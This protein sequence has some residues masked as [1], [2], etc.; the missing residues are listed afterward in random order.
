METALTT[1]TQL[2]VLSDTH[3]SPAATPDGTW[4]NTLRRSV[5]SQLLQ[6]ALAEIAQAGHRHVLLLG[7]ISD[8]GTPELIGAALSAIADAGLRSWA[9]PGN[10]DAAEDS[11]ALDTAAEQASSCLVVHHEPLRLGDSM[12]VAGPALRSSDGGQTCEATNLPDVAGVTS[13]ILVWAGHY[14]LLSQ[15]QTLL[16]AGLRYAGDLINRQQARDAAERHAGPVLVLHGHLH[17][18]VT[19]HD[20]RMLQLGFPALVEW[21]HAWTDLRIE[22]SPGGATV[23]TAIRP[24]A[25]E[26]SQRNRNTMLAGPQQ[27]WQL[28]G[29]RWRPVSAP[30]GGPG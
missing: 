5:S 9:V 27:T 15:E 1:A 4:N 3:L 29:E 16:A 26:W 13:P 23:R 25:G 24:V 20:G 6:V 28:D 7:D 18:A 12:T 30:G 17:T 2:A 22:T 19:G 14:P 8:D 21:P 11:G 10:H